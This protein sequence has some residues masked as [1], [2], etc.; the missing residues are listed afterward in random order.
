MKLRNSIL[1]IPVLVTVL[2]C[3]H[4][5]K[6]KIY[7][8]SELEIIRQEFSLP[9]EKTF[10]LDTNYIPYLFSLDTSKYADEI[11][12]HYQPILAAYYDKAGKLISFHINCYA[13]LGVKDKDD[14][15]WNQQNAFA[16]FIPKTVAPIDSIL[17][18]PKHLQF[19]KTFDN[20][21]IDTTGFSA[22][23]YT[24]IIH[25]GKKWRPRDCQN[26]FA[27]V[28]QNATLANDKKINILYV[29]NDNNW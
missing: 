28:K 22:F 6:R 19:L 23:D 16:S 2:S 17:P 27:I 13:G 21:A 26:L 15:N 12:N 10:M 25:W 14:L 5:V 29:N 20:K 7:S 8:S 4:N 9:K 3:R 18:L 1:L 24:I 11:Q